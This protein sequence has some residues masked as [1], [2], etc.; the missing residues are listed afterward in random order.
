MP[1]AIQRKKRQV[2]VRSQISGTADK[3]RL[4]VFKSLNN[5]YA[6]LIDDVT[7]TVIVEVNDLKG[8]K[9]TKTES[10]KAVGMEL[11]KQAAAK[12]IETCVFDRAGYLYHGR[13]KAL[14]DGAREGG[15]KF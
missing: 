13:V 5:I 9:G 10:A 11:A 12:K 6:R 7:G 15:L 14:A 8:K 1:N 2:R 3:P 4:N